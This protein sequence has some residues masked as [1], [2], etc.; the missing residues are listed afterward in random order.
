LDGYVSA[1]LP[2]PIRIPSL[3][4]FQLGLLALGVFGLRVIGGEFGFGGPRPVDVV[5][6]YVGR[7]EVRK[8]T[9]NQIAPIALGSESGF[10]SRDR[11]LEQD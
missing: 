6:L 11:P 1:T 4:L 3:A 9:G 8:G 10:R 7:I 5:G 2:G